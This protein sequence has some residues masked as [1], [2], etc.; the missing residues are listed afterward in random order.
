[1]SVCPY[2]EQCE[3]NDFKKCGVHFCVLSACLYPAAY[4]Q[5]ITDEINRLIISGQ[6]KTERFK[7]LIRERE[8]LEP[9]DS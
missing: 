7:K 5:A 4:Y 6:Y 2:P 1:M 9:S 3:Y 8:K